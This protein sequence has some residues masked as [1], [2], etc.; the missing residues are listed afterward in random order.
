[1]VV[2][3]AVDFAVS[4]K[5]TAVAPTGVFGVVQAACFQAAVAGKVTLVVQYAQVPTESR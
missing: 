2:I 4:P 3:V 5:L 1:M